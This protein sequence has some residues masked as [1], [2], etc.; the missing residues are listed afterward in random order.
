MRSY[1]AKYSVT[2]TVGME[3]VQYGDVFNSIYTRLKDMNVLMD[4]MVS[5]FWCLK[6]N[7]NTTNKNHPSAVMPVKHEETEHSVSS[8][9]CVTLFY[10]IQIK[11]M[12]GSIDKKEERFYT[13]P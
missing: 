9:S 10:L 12:I 7:S 5:V 11:R 8:A 4:K 2:T 6:S 1:E 13:K 3:S